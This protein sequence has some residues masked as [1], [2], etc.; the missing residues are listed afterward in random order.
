MACVTAS[1]P[2]CSDHEAGG[3]V[4]APRVCSQE[5]SY[6]SQLVPSRLSQGDGQPGRT[7]GG[8]R[9][10]GVLWANCWLEMGRKLFVTS[11]LPRA[12]PPNETRSAKRLG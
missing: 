8:V 3:E 9:A 7:T 10:C 4:R 12:K 1:A 11:C 6:S 2:E 5:R